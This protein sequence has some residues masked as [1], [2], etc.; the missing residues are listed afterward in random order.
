MLPKKGFP[1]VNEYCKMQKDVK[2]SYLAHK[3]R[4]DTK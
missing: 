4:E 2:F 3:L 1:K